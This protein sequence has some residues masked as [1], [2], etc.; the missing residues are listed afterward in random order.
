MIVLFMFFLG[1]GST[2][3]VMTLTATD[4]QS[5]YDVIFGFVKGK[6]Q[7]GVTVTIYQLRCGGFEDKIKTAVTGKDGFYYF[8]ELKP[9]KVYKI[10]PGKERYR[11]EPEFI[12]MLLPK[13]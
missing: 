3:Q 5:Q 8:N 10:V 7:E 12:E 9:G 6:G 2:E 4:V 11:F 1:I 13:H